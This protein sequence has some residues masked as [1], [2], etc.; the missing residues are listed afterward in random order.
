M[1]GKILPINF[2]F[3]FNSMVKGIFEVSINCYPL[4]FWNQNRNFHKKRKNLHINTL[5]SFQ[6]KYNTFIRI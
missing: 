2:Q 3:P 6:M 4:K 5:A 1:S